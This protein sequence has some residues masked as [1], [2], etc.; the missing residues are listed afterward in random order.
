[1]KVDVPRAITPKVLNGTVVQPKKMLKIN[2]C[3]ISFGGDSPEKN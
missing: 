3:N 1:M 2:P